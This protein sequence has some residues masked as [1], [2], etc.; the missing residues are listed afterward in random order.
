MSDAT[1]TPLQRRAD[2]SLTKTADAET[3]AAG[4]S[5][6]FTVTVTNAGPSDATGVE[7]TD[8]LPAPYE[9]D[10]Q[11][12]DPRCAL[13]AGEVTCDLDTVAPGAAAVV[14]IAATVPAD[15][16]PG[17][18]ENTARWS[19]TSPIPTT[20][21]NTASA[22]VEVIQQADL[23]VTKTPAADGVLLGGTLAYTLVVTN[24]GPSDAAAVVLTESI[25]AGTAVQTLPDDCTGTGPVTCA[26]GDL[27]AGSTVS[28]EI[29]LAVPETTQVGPLTNTASVSSSTDDP[30]E[31]NNEAAAT[32]EAIAQ[33]DVVLDKRLVTE[34]PV[35]GEPVVFEFVLTNRGPTIAPRPSLSDPLPPGTGFVSFTVPGGECQ[36]DETAEEDVPTASCTLAALRVGASVTARL[37]LDTDPTLS[38]ITNTGYAGSGGLDDVPADNEDTAAAQTAA[39]AAHGLPLAR[40]SVPVPVAGVPVAELTVPGVVHHRLD[41]G[42]AVL[43]W[44]A[45]NR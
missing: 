37:V 20:S 25:P 45:A 22:E 29:V 42:A 30:D 2:L 13:D 1:T 23:S 11:N 24:S 26:L 7:L 8:L 34:N 4:G 32:V 19:R 5:T 15:A 39:G 43:E 36:L 31:Q 40:V 9:F 6:A 10:P 44:S 17:T 28:L 38:S 16:P 12:S 14:V 27:P 21:N 41:L 3:A 35:A 18:V 33:A